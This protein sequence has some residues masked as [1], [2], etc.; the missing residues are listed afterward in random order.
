[1]KV[2][3][4][5]RFREDSQVLVVDLLKLKDR[6]AKLGLWRTFHAIDGAT[7]AVGWEIAEKL[8]P[9]KS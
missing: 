2:R 7:T 1:M 3:E 8:K 6:A 5:R 9:V 4:E